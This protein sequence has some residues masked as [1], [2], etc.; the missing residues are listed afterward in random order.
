MVWCWCGDEVIIPA[1]TYSATALAVL[2]VGAKPIMVDVNENFNISVQEIE[3]AITTKTKAIIPVDFGGFPCDYEEIQNLALKNKHLFK[4]NTPVQKKLNRILVL[5]DAAH[6]MGAKY[7]NKN[8]GVLCDLTVFSFHAVKNVTT[9]EGGV[10]CINLPDPFSN[11]EVY[12]FMRCYSQWP[13]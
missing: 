11:K 4:P 1:Y 3:N 2:N 9:A 7:K 5:S 10:I 8:A 12:K 6:S 13:N